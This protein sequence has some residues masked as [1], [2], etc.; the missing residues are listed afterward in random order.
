MITEKTKAPKRK[1]WS[2]SVTV[3]GLTQTI[4]VESLDNGGYLVCV[5]EYGY[6]PSDV[7]RTNY[8]DNT[9]KLYSEE[10]P[11]EKK[12]EVNLINELSSILTLNN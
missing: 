3:N 7:K 1:E 10:N 9:K 4:R 8:I 2:K 11:L 12:E 5:S 6:K